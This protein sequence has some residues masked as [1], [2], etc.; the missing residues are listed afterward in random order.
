[1]AEYRTMR[2]GL[3]SDPYIE[4]LKAYT[5]LVYIY[6]ITSCQSNLGVT[7]IT[8]RKI[9]FDTG[10]SDDL[11]V[12]A[13]NTLKKDGKLI[14]DED[15]LLLVNFVKHQTTTS[16]LIIKSLK[17]AMRLVRSRIILE[18]IRTQYPFLQEDKQY[19]YPSNRV[20][21]PPLKEEGEVEVEV[22]VELKEEPKD[23]DKEKKRK[24]KGEGNGEGKGD[25]ADG[26]VTAAELMTL[27]NEVMPEHGFRPIARIT[28]DRSAKLHTRQKSIP[29]AKTLDFWKKIYYVMAHSPFLRGEVRSEKHKDWQAD[30]DFPL[31]SDDRLVK[32][33]E[34]RYD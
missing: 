30:F 14:A 3:W 6:L 21:I 7:E 27:W 29:E 32:I 12:E 2:I 23:K 16:P 8:E 17:R 18:T 5:K 34:G 20:S 9:A 11:V 24:R 4:G 26:A 25:A 13:L 10:L 19:G 15:E 33:M 28:A 1:M 31:K 22:E